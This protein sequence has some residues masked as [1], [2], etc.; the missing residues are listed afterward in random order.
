MDAEYRALRGELVRL[1]VAAG[2]DNFTAEELAAADGSLTDLGY[3]S[4]AYMRLI[5]AIENE[6]GVYLD[7]EADAQHFESVDSI[8]RL[9]QL[10]RV[11]A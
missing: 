3:T 9:V 2:E 4:L 7:P 8:A 5:D 10:A 11:N 1:V 6:L